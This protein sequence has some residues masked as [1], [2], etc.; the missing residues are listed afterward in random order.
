M[1]G[2][3]V[4]TLLPKAN[5]NEAD[6]VIQR[7]KHKLKEQE[8]EGAPIEFCSGFSEYHPDDETTVDE[9]ITS[10]DSC[11]YQEKMEKKRKDKK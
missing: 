10:A 5:Q 11:M 2:D 1:G 4:L 3:E 8:I 7:I 6:N 9:L